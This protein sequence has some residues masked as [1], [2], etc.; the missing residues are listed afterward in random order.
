[1]SELHEPSTIKPKDP[2]PA[3]E[4]PDPEE[5]QSP[6]LFRVCSFFLRIYFRLWNRCSIHGVENI[7]REGGVMLVSNHQSHIDP[8]LIGSFFRN[9]LVN[10]MA[11]SE[12]WNFKPLA[13]LIS[14]LGAYPIQ[15]GAADR[16]AIQTTARLLEKGHVVLVFPEGTRTLDGSLGEVKPGAAMLMNQAR[17]VAIVPTLVEG[18][19]ECMGGKKIFP[20]PSK[21][22]VYYGESFRIT[23]LPNLPTVKKQLYQ[24]L[25]EEIMKRIAG[26]KETTSR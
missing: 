9:R 11:K 22:N 23:D 14:L 5:A 17:D 24:A 20:R 7:P 6:A 16:K 3:V 10:F 25:S 12:L 8:P 26:A 21:I 2:P 19:F 18:S 4:I 1:M 13:I 15:R